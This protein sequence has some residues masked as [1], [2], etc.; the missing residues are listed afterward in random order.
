[1]E[2]RVWGPRGQSPKCEMQE[3][4]IFYGKRFM[5]ATSH[6]NGF[7]ALLACGARFIAGTDTQITEVTHV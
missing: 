4:W 2:P 6:P 1:M 5:L 7:S 3:G